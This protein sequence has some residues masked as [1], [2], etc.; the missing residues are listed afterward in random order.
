MSE[1]SFRSGR[2]PAINV[3]QIS[4]QAEKLPKQQDRQCS[5]K[6]KIYGHLCQQCCCEKATIFTYAECVVLTLRIQD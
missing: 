4:F 3:S 2:F 5:Y 6:N 1:F